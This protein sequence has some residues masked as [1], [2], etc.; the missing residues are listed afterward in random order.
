[1]KKGNKI[2]SNRTTI[3]LV[4]LSAPDAV[5]YPEF[6][7]N[8]K[9]RLEQR[10]IKVVEGKT[11]HTSHFYMAEDPKVIAQ[12]LHEM[13]LRDDVDVIMCAGGG[14]CINKI[15]PFLDF[16][17]MRK[18]LKPFIGISNIV[19]LMTAMLQNDMVSF[20][21]PFSIWSY[22]LPNTPTD[23]TH[24]NWISVLK[25]YTGRLPA[26]SDWKCY[27]PGVG[28][29]ELIGGNIFSLGTVIGTKYCPTELFKNKILILEDIGKTFDRLDSVITHMELLGILDN[30]K[31]V[32]IGKLKDCFSPEN[33]K[34]E[35]IDFIDM[36][37]G[38]YDF[39]IIYDCDFGHVP[40]NLCLPFGCQTRIIAKE[41][42]ELILLESGV[43]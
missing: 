6:Y 16:D 18:N 11:L 15:F 5:W 33:V 32:V 36:T 34:M 26:V 19:A 43:E 8:G 1:M 39:P 23:Y 9:E 13:F 30:I 37:F 35:V 12:G 10:G 17:L 42:P 24:N 31:G 29:G 22:G 3:G 2:I 4:G 27:R 14:V 25:G 40:D 20:H 38:K 28:E 7:K 41:R 21:G